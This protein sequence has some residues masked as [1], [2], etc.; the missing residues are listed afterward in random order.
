MSGLPH[1]RIESIDLVKGAVIL[2]MALDHVRDFFHADAFNFEPTDLAHT[3][4]VLFFT[5][6]ITD[7]CAPAFCLLA[8]TSAYFVGRRKTKAELS[9]FL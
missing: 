7:F 9:K 2:I 5:R 4:F 1:K 3:S 6:L 8:G